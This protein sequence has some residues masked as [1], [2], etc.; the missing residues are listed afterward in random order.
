[1]AAVGE[2]GKKL[3]ASYLEYHS[4][5]EEEEKRRKGWMWWKRWIWK[6]R[7]K[8]ESEWGKVMIAALHAV[9]RSCSSQQPEGSRAQIWPANQ[10]VDISIR[11]RFFFFF[12]CL[13]LPPNQTS[14]TLLSTESRCVALWSE[15][16]RMFLQKIWIPFHFFF[17]GSDINCQVV[18]PQ[19]PFAGDLRVSPTT[20]FCLSYDR[21]EFYCGPILK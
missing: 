2:S 19:K 1:M 14:H 17:N 8:G 9:S 18:E 16:S 10:K 3:L 20:V 13:L 11:L 21:M 6:R 7:E 15:G 12:F 4:R 5:W